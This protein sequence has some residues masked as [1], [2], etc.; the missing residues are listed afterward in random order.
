MQIINGKIAT[1]AA[2]LNDNPFIYF[3]EGECLYCREPFLSISAAAR[4]CSPACKQSAYRQRS[5]ERNAQQRFVTARG[6]R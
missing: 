5:K 4:Y 2:A 1:E 6:E 3:H